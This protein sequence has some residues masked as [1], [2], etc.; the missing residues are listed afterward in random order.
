VLKI[1]AKRISHEN[2][3]EFG[4][5]LT[6]PENVP[7]SKGAEYTFWS[8]MVHFLIPGETE[9]GLCT[10]SRQPAAQILGVERH[11]ETP[12]ILIPIDA[13]FILPLLLDGEPAQQM[14]AFQVNVGEA[15]VIDRGVWHGACFPVGK[16]EATYFVIF[17]RHT[18]Y[19]DVEKKSIEPVLI[20][21]YANNSDPKK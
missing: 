8:D 3:S 2:F 1:H 9:I 16:N 17:R 4:S 21:P 14:A 7:T 13:S 5:V 6:D 12:E 11:N 19:E 10:V 18:P 15:V 20:E